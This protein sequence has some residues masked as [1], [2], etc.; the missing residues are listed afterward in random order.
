MIILVGKSGS[1]KSTF[2]KNITA[3]MSRIAII[4]RD[5]IRRAIVGDLDNYYLRPDMPRLEK[6]VTNMEDNLFLNYYMES[7]S[8]VIDN[9]NLKQ[10][11]IKRW[12][13]IANN[14]HFDIRFK[15]FDVDKE[16]CKKRVMIRDFEGKTTQ[17]LVEYID[18]QDTDFNN[19]IQWINN[20]HKDKIIV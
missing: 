16:E 2:S 13:D 6:I 11:Y 15:I 1:G 7:I 9:T 3:S 17:Q 8:V 10:K 18:K 20:N 19:I 4:N 14:Y 5:N 12:L